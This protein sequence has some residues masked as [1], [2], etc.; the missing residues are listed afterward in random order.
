MISK[1]QQKYIQSLQIKKYRYENQSFLVEGAKSVIEL[2]NSD[3]EIE[4]CFFTEKFINTYQINY[5][6]YELATQDELEKIGSLQS[7]DSAIAIAKMKKNKLLHCNESEFVLV[8]DDIRDPGNL[9]TIVR[10]ADWYNIKKILLSETSVDFYNPKVISATMGSFTRIE[11][12]YGDLLEY[13]KNID[14][15]LLIGAFLDGENIHQFDFP[16][17]GFII[18]GN[19][20]NGINKELSKLISKK[21]TIPRFG[22][23]ESLNA[24]VATAIVLDNLRRKY[25]EKL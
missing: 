25:N 6:N 10:L 2:L 17:S 22:N 18:I 3:F 1:Q 7:N 21:I 20:S 12:W 14:N 19:E 23:A 16:S 13:F 8:L 24:G 15:Q 11:Y 4:K 5:K 9:G